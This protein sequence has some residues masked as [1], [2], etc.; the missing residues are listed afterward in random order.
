MS[1]S[2][3]AALADFSVQG[4]T[5]VCHG[6]WTQR[7][8]TKL[9]YRIQTF[10]VPACAHVTVQGAGITNMDTAG[11]WLL[12]QLQATLQAGHTSSDLQGFSP[13]H[14]ALLALVSAETIISP[15]I[16]QTL[17]GMAMV[18]KSTLNGLS[19]AKQFLT[20]IG[21]ACC[22]FLH[23]CLGKG[24][25]R[26]IS[27]LQGIDVTGYRAVPIVALLSFLIGVVLTYQMGDQLRDY[28]A[29]IYIVDLLGIAVFREFGPLITAIIVAGRTGS[30][31]TAQ[32][33]TMNLRE[34][35]DALR[36]MGLSPTEL[37]VVPRVLALIIALPLLTVLADIAGIM[38]GMFMAKE[39]LSIDYMDFLHRFGQ[40]IEV[41]QFTLGLIK[42]PV[43][44]ALIATIGCFQGFQVSGGAES[45]GSH[46]TR[47]VVQGIFMII[48]ADAAFSVLYT[49]MGM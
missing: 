33:G 4:Q 19:E 32:I 20:F 7:G 34:E 15:S 22:A 14:Q 39:M 2:P 24:R 11:A 23:V 26:W 17:R 8:I 25:V 6:N 46:T 10:P 27:I 49:A 30:A 21:E 18:G 36:T 48:V 9:Q 40:V 1:Q 41:K 29:D 13:E 12:H 45:V 38:G 16:P 28:G 35:L 31:Y 5:L 42:T 3:T 47:S 44:A 43:F 37:L